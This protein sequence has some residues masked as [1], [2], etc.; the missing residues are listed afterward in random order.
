MYCHV[1][2][3]EIWICWESIDKYVKQIKSGMASPMR[4]DWIEKQSI[5]YTTA[6]VKEAQIKAVT[7]EDAAVDNQQIE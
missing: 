1:K 3:T 4:A 5:I 7:L 6:R 2:N